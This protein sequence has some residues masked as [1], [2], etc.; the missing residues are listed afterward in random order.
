M[1]SSFSHVIKLRIILLFISVFFN[2]M[3]MP[4]VVVY[5]VEHVGINIASLM[6]FGVGLA[7]ILGG[8][9]GGRFGDKYGRKRLIV[10]GEIGSGIGFLIACSASLFNEFLSLIIF[11]S[12]L[13]I[14]FFSGLSNPAYGALIIDETTT[15]NR[16][17]LY[18]VLLW[19]S[20][21]AFA[22]GSIL[23][24]FFFYK[25]SAMLFFFVGCSSF[26]SCIC[27]TIWVKERYI[28]TNDNSINSPVISNFGKL[29]V[30]NQI[31][32]SPAFISIVLLSLLLALMNNQLSY[33]L[34]VHYVNLFNS[35]GYT[36]LGFLRSE[37]T[38]ITVFLTFFITK[39]LK[40]VYEFKTLSV[41]ICMFFLGYIALSIGQNQ[42][43]LYIA[44]AV[45]TIGQIIY[46]PVIQNFT[47]E[48]IPYD[49]RSTYLSILDV[50]GHIGGI[51]AFLFVPLMNYV[52]PFIITVIYLLFGII[53]LFI[54]YRL[55]HI[56]SKVNTSIR[57]VS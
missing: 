2:A 34:S 30:Y 7:G 45:M 5:F 36:I 41:G 37:N 26:L 48:V 32:K 6:V 27:I 42:S 12:F 33:Y 54:I 38:L 23:G 44:M 21:M 25:F 8:L 18:A 4:Y 52:Q 29:E 9:L 3:V 17:P 13:F 10:I 47:A 43:I 1:Y 19:V 24:G 15:E 11:L 56:N 53:S 51:F 16:K 22:L 14:Y 39:I 28:R 55:K 35:A 46:S 31:L 20:N 49:H 50:I 40:K 57:S